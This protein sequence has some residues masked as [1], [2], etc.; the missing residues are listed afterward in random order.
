MCCIHMEDV[1]RQNF[2]KRL[3]KAMW[4][5]RAKIR[6]H[7]KTKMGNKENKGIKGKKGQKG[8]C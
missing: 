7:H 6:Q 3:R 4:S 8:D 1:V 5:R 2:L